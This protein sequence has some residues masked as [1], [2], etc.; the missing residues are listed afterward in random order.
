MHEKSVVS[1]MLTVT[2]GPIS[3]FYCKSEIVTVWFQND[4]CPAGHVLTVK[5]VM[6]ADVD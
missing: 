1:L 4:I 5:V 6:L 3:V 2:K